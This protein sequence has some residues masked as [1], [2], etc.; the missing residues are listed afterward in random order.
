V[1]LDIVVGFG[2]LHAHVHRLDNENIG[3]PGPPGVA[4]TE[5]VIPS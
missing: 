2:D 5:V 1:E 3:E 4:E